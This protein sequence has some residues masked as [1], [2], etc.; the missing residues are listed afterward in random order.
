M[1]RSGPWA[2]PAWRAGSSNRLDPLADP[3]PGSKV[4]TEQ[5]LIAAANR[6]YVDSYRKLVE[7]CTDGEIH[8]VGGVFAFVTGVPLSL[9]NGCIVVEPATPS[10]LEAAMDWVAS[11][12]VPHRVWVATS[13]CGL[14]DVP[15]A[16]GF[17]RDDYPGMILHPVPAPPTPPA[18]VTVVPLTEVGLDEYL[19]V[20]I[21]GG[22]PPDVAGRLFPASFAADPDVQLFTGRLD[23]R[24]VGTALAIRGGDVSGV[25]AVGTRPPAR[26][27]GL[28][29]ALTWAAVETGRT[30]G[31]DTIVLQASEMGLPIYEAMGFRTVV[32]YA[33]FT[34][35]APDA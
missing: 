28:G 7:H 6:N 15:L 1:G 22:V 35:P 25:Y 29:T 16:R 24:V 32:T 12:A 19:A 11:R 21:E 18:G 3:P 4:R 26:R 10:Q 2:S 34:R 14:G 17:V 31:C 13:S 27:R 23:G 20:W 8:E 9:F 5:D 33:E 30:W